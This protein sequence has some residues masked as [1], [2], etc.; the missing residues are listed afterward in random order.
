MIYFFNKDL[1]VIDKKNEIS[2]SFSKKANRE[3]SGKIEIADMPNKESVYISIYEH[4]QENFYSTAEDQTYIISGFIQEVQL[5]L[6]SVSI[7]FSTFEGLLKKHKLPKIFSNFDEMKASELFANLFYFFVPI[8]KSKKKDFT[9]NNGF[10]YGLNAEYA[11]GV[12]KADHIEFA[13]VK[14]GDL[15]L[16]F[17]SQYSSQNDFRYFE[18]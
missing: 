4:T 16:A 2:F 15:H 6:N 11:N 3:G 17:D 5:N 7:S 8:I 1:R 18:S 14:D 10:D 12:L 9:Y 13:K